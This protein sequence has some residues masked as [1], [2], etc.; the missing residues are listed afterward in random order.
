MEKGKKAIVLSGGGS[1]GAYQ[2]G[3]W[4]ALRRLHYKYDIVTG[5]SVGALNG[6]LMVQ[7]EYYKC[8]KLWENIN[9][10]VLFSESFP[11]KIEGLVGKTKV[12]HKYAINFFKNGGI[13]TSRFEKLIYNAYNPF[14]FFCSSIDYGMITYNLTS[15]KALE[16]TKKDMTKESAPLYII[17][18]ASC[19]P[20]FPKKKINGENYIDG[21]YS[22][23]LPIN[24]AISLGA[25]EIIAVDLEAVGRKQKVHSKDVK[26]TFIKPR[27]QIVSFLIFKED[28]S[29]KAIQYGYND[30]MKTFGKL[31]GNI[32]T[33]YQKQLKHEYHK[34]SSHLK[35]A[36]EMRIE[37]NEKNLV[38]SQLLKMS[39]FHKLLEDKTGERQEKFFYQL[40]ERIGKTLNLDDTKIYSMKNF[41][42]ESLEIL[43]KVET[44]NFSKVEEKMKKQKLRS[45][46]GTSMLLRYL[47]DKVKEVPQSKKEKKDYCR[48]ALLF[49]KDFIAAVYLNLL[50]EKY[51]IISD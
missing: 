32:F 4:K 23:N 41:S 39:L 19:Y 42:K 28:L 33:F 16:I 3:V 2:V 30:T 47:Y 8:L 27:N 20:A 29:K 6:V 11:K 22:D 9:F 17:A 45:L 40:I 51:H 7:K 49:P 46:L 14:R 36:L 34:N 50:N 26:I 25:T 10:D 24:L 37:V 38:S 1:R 12:Y 48:Y 31:D 18:S 5:T 15:H 13:N 44:T 35:S 43:S 21:G